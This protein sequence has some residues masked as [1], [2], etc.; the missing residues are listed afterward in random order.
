MKRCI[1]RNK[2]GRSPAL[3]WLREAERVCGVCASGT[4]PEKRSADGG[5]GGGGGGGGFWA[6]ARA[7]AVNLCYSGRRRPDV[8]G[9]SSSG[10]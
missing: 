8:A 3:N 4:E 2:P 5:G 9:L 1:S 10:R 6:H 7:G